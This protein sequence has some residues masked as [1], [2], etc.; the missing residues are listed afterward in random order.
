MVLA[1]FPPPLGAADI[2]P[3]RPG[4]ERR[5][6]MGGPDPD[7]TASRCGQARPDGGVAAGLESRR[8]WRWPSR[9]SADRICRKSEAGT[10][11]LEL[12]G[13]ACLASS[14]G[15]IHPPPRNR[16]MDS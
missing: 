1:Y 16:D 3:F 9:C 2:G 6:P 15:L 11:L 5:S 4:R 7:D 13:E 8:P 10:P 12:V 14:R